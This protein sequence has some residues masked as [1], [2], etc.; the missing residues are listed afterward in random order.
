MIYSF[1]LHHWWRRRTTHWGKWR[2]SRLGR[3]CKEHLKCRNLTSR[4][5]CRH[6]FHPHHALRSQLTTLYHL[7]THIHIIGTIL[8]SS[9]CN[10]ELNLWLWSNWRWNGGSTRYWRRYGRASLRMCC[11]CR[12]NRLSSHSSLC[13]LCGN[14]LSIFYCE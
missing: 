5:P 3:R 6:T 10:K 9:Y 1:L 2:R 4:S 12:L 11:Y 13:G 7:F 8:L 14:L